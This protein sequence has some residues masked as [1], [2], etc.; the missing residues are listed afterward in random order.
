[1]FIAMAE[2]LRVVFI[3]LSDRIH[4]MKTLKFHPRIEKQEKIA[5]E[6]LNI[7]APIADRL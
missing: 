6:T 5:L 7:F 4:N 3:K 2:D 1:M